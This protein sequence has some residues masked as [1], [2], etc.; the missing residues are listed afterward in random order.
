MS[1]SSVFSYIPVSVVS[2]KGETKAKLNLYAATYNEFLRGLRADRTFQVTAPLAGRLDLISYQLYST[3]DYWWI[4]QKVNGIIHPVYDVYESRILKV[5]SPSA[6]ETA[7]I[8]AA[9]SKI[10]STQRTLELV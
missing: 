1:E 8:A 10:A 4:I 5:P 3:V 6:M 7:Q 2:E 9:I